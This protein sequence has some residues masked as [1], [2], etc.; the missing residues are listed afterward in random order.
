M[1]NRAGF[2]GEILFF[3]SPHHRIT[4]FTAWGSERFIHMLLAIRA[5]YAV[6]VALGISPV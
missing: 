5:E 4:L 2:L 3:W 6:E 1:A